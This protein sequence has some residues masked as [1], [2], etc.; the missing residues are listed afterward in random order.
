MLLSFK[1]REY[2]NELERISRSR[3][4]TLQSTLTRAQANGLVR[5]KRGV[6]QLTAK[7]QAR[8]KPYSAQVLQKNVV[9]MV[10][11]DIPEEL[12]SCRRQLRSLLHRLGF[13]QTQKSVWTTRFDYRREVLQAAK[14]LGINQYV[15][16]YESAKVHL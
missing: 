12:V 15:Q 4:P 9:L 7:G 10:I 8:I 14:T 5:R 1:P 6:P 2:F 3:K 16:V 11:F 13:Q